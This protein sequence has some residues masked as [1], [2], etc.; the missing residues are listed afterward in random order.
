MLTDHEF[1]VQAED[2]NLSYITSEMVFKVKRVDVITKVVR[3]DRK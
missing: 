1:G 2:I 3:V